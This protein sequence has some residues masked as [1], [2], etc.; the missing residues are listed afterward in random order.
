M[1]PDEY[2]AALRAAGIPE[3]LPVTELDRQA[4]LL[5]GVG[6]RTARRYRNGEYKIPTRTEITLRV[7][8][9]HRKAAETAFRQVP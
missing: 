6:Q 3:S 9:A 4:A 2:L 1:K 8:A 7:L 5:L